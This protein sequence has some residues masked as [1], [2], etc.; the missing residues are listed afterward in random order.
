MAGI[1]D[2]GFRWLNEYE[3]TW[4]AIQEDDE[5]SLQASI[6]DIIHTAKRKRLLVRK[7]NVRLGMMRHLYVVVDMSKSMKESDL[8]RPSKIAC[9]T[10]L[11]ELFIVEYFDQ[12]PIS[13]LGIIIT[14]NKR[15]EKLTDL[16]G[17]PRIHISA[18][19]EAAGKKVEGEASLQN[20]L[21]MALKLLKNLPSHASR[22]ILV[23]YGSLTS[24]DPSDIFETVS[25]LKEQ[26]I[27]CS[28]VGLSAEIKVCK[29]I[30]SET[31]GV[32]SVILDEN[33]CKDLIFE[34][35]RPPETKVN[36]DA[37]LIRMG[38]PKHLTNDYP[39]LCMCHIE[40]NKIQGLDCTGYFCPQCKSKYCELPVECKI[41]NLTLV[42]AP[43]LARSYQHLFPLPAFEEL[44]RDETE[45]CEG[46]LNI[47]KDVK[48]Y[49]CKKCN[50]I[51]CNDCDL[52]IHETLHTCPGCSSHYQ[53]QENT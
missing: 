21:E 33:H 17:N 25:H 37:S 32:Y 15:C 12:N 40:T 16:S 22:E 6:D 31:K 26:N 45:T 3:K 10:K 42:S 18:L 2:G 19:Q 7:G 52:F 46:C 5:G 9:V 20:C 47:C 1:E 24:C 27:R 43:H 41:C 36:I 30:T 11:L 28:V 4:E 38:F 51:F 48:V 29:T 44:Q 14:K 35:V 8:L 53:F 23:V 50:Q 34:H 49:M 39:S 13:Q